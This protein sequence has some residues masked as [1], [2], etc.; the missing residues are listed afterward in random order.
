[1]STRIRR[2]RTVWQNCPKVQAS[3]GHSSTHGVFSRRSTCPVTALIINR[4]L[5]TH[6]LAISHHL[7]KP[8]ILLRVFFK[9]RPN[10]FVPTHLIPEFEHLVRLFKRIHK[11]IPLFLT[12]VRLFERKHG[13]GFIEAFGG[14][15]SADAPVCIRKNR[16][17]RM[18][19]HF[20]KYI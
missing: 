7:K 19:N 8:C 14:V 13:D 20:Q 1:M 3:P 12:L 5:G 15:N 17:G 18:G 11:G 10:R 4:D 2:K 9:R 6:G 16:A